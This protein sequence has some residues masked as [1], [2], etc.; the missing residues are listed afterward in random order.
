VRLTQ[1]RGKLAEHGTRFRDF[2]NFD[3]L[4]DY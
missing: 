4:F 2:G 1:Q 3:V